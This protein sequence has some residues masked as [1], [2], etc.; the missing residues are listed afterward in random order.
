MN[1]RRGELIDL[2]VRVGYENMDPDHREEY[3]RLQFI[4]QKAIDARLPKPSPG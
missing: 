1:R 3:D 4:S 2:K